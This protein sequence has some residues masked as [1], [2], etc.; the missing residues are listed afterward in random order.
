M[1]EID[2]GIRAMQALQKLLPQGGL[3]NLG[4]VKEEMDEMISPEFGPYFLANTALHLLSVCERCG[5]CCLEEKGIAV[6]IDDCRR[7][8]RHL[9]LS[10]KRF[11][12]DYTR[13][14]DLLGEQVGSA[15]MLGKKE[16]EPCP[17]FDNSLP[18]C[19]IHPVKPQVCVAALYLTKMNLLRCEEQKK[20]NDFPICSADERLRAR[21]ADFRSRLDEDAKNDLESLF[22]SARPE[23]ELFRLMLRLKG[24]EI[25]FGN[26]RAAL[27][28]RRLGLARVP[29]DEEMKGTAFVY[30]FNLLDSE[31]KIGVM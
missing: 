18:G 21:I 14:H 5:R 24:M 3:K 22:K 4:S 20:V 25:Y 10:L 13:P 31:G 15:R 30:A 9:G 29:G 8:A 6:S 26:E 1:E 27:L 2:R 12:R 28:A 17:F 7:I 23:V 16:G 19:R 11:M